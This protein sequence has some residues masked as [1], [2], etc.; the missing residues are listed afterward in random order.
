MLKHAARLYL[1][2]LEH[3]GHGVDRTAWHAGRVDTVDGREPKL[4]L[5]FDQ[6][7]KG[8]RVLLPKAWQDELPPGFAAGLRQKGASLACIDKIG[9]I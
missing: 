1:R 9:M 4:A 8:D 5:I 7:N 3:L 2:V 6:V